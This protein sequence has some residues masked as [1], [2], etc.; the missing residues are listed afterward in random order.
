MGGVENG[1]GLKGFVPPGGQRLRYS[2][3]WL[4][5]LGRGGESRHPT[6]K[7]LGLFIDTSRR[8]NFLVLIINR[9]PEKRAAWHGKRTASVFCMRRPRYSPRLLWQQ[10]ICFYNILHESFTCKGG[11]EL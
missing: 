8:E 11:T 2:T 10:F 6:G 9:D 4:A 5:G 3:L 7:G 1:R